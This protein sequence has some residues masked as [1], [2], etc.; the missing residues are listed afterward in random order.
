LLKYGRESALPVFKQF[1]PSI[2]GDSN[3][4]H[5]AA[6]AYA[7]GIQ[8]SAQFMNEPPMYTGPDT[9][10]QRAWQI[11]GNILF[12]VCRSAREPE[13]AKNRIEG[14]WDRLAGDV[15]LAAVDVLYSLHNG[16]SLV[17][18]ETEDELDL[19]IR[20]PAAVKILLEHALKHRSSLSSVFTCF[21]RGGHR[22]EALVLF[23]IKELGRIGNEATIPMLQEVSD[24]ARLGAEAI[25][26]IRDIRESAR[27]PHINF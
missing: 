14:L 11:V 9:P 26:A 2:D 6:V 16:L 27:G 20:Y 1:A 5:E 19:V 10:E 21:S 8:G 23:V 18:T 4:P 24:D 22:N 25:A 15:G 17:F 7:F 13:V 3:S 12:W